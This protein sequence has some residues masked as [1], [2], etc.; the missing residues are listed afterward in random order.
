MPRNDKGQFEKGASGNPAGRPKKYHGVLSFKLQLPKEPTAADLSAAINRMT[1]EAAAGKRT[2]SET[3]M[4]V[5]I[6][7][8]A[9][10][11]MHQKEAHDIS[12]QAMIIKGLQAIKKGL[13]ENKEAY[14][15]QELQDLIEKAQAEL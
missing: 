8:Q 10:A 5:K 1:I 4:M 11:A 9:M 2:L 15:A 3:E 14:S 7:R 13:L 6:L 12:M